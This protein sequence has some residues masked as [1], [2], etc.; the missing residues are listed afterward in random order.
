MIMEVGT[1]AVS[2][3]RPQQ[4]PV[5]SASAELQQKENSGK[6]L[7]VGNSEP[8]ADSRPK[9]ETKDLEKMAEAL[10]QFMKATQRSLQFTL[11]DDTGR[12]VIKVI[13]KETQ[14]VVRQFP[15]EEMLSI[16]RMITE[17]LQE[18]V[19]TSTGI[20]LEEQT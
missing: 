15:P 11:D 19:D 4:Q 5:N 6:P 17:S 13:N 20:L 10:N 18:A 1:Q 8:A 16:S 14:E 12:T 7:P 3:N 2:A 9:P